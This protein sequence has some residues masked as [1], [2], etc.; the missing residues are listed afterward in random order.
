M[1]VY[2]VIDTNVFVSAMLS[3]HNDAATVQLVGRMLLG[4]IIP[5]Y[6]REIMQE[7]REVLGR[8][9]SSSSRKQ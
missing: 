3:K 5:V 9:N 4:E 2:A 8:K 1:S 6:S 7:Y